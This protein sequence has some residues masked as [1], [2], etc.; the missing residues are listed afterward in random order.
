MRRNS[1]QRR[2]SAAELKLHTQPSD[3]WVAIYGNVYD[4]TMWLN[5]H[6]GGAGVILGVAG[7]DATSAFDDV[8]HTQY[9]VALL[10][11]YLVGTLNADSVDVPSSPLMPGPQG[12]KIGSLVGLKTHR[13]PVAERSRASLL[14][15]GG[16]LLLLVGMWLI[17]RHPHT[18]ATATI[19]TGH[20]AGKGQPLV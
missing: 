12:S 3:C 7:A 16:S 9:A 10:D 18:S 15:A 20:D 14:L 2:I 8:G 19:P 17:L 13:K 11:R 5:D 4:I 6:P 1:V